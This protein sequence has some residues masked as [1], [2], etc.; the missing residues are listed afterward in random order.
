MGWCLPPTGWPTRCPTTPGGAVSSSLELRRVPAA[1]EGEVACNRHAPL[2]C[3]DVSWGAILC[4]RAEAA[5]DRAGSQAGPGA[6]LAVSDPACR[7]STS[8]SSMAVGAKVGLVLEVTVP[9]TP[10]STRCAQPLLSPAGS[11]WMGP[12]RAVA[13]PGS[14]VDREGDLMNT[15][16]AA[17]VGSSG[18]ITVTG[19]ALTLILGG[20]ESRRQR[21]P[22]RPQSGVWGSNGRGGRAGRRLTSPREFSVR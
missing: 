1:P 12:N 16:G 19:A 17:A 13:W 5:S 7:S 21:R 6:R 4:M 10:G 22:S 9:P 18:G 11:P 14:G 15:A 3:A 8:A 20:N 2:L